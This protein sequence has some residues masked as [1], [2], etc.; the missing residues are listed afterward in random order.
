MDFRRI[1]KNTVQC[2][3]SEE[4]MNAYGFKVEDFFSDQQK[5]R[6]FLE[7]IVERA[8]EE[9]GYQAKSGM[10]SMQIMKMPN[11]DLAIT[12]SDRDKEEGFQSV[13][14]QFQQL[15]N[16]LDGSKNL[17]RERG[18]DEDAEDDDDAWVRELAAST[19]LD[20][21][22]RERAEQLEAESKRLKREKKFILAPKAYHFSSYTALEQFIA[23]IEVDRP[24]N[25][26]VYWE[27]AD[28]SYYMLVK[29]GRLKM[30]D[31]HL[32]CQRLSEFSVLFSAKPYVEEY[33]REHFKC[34]IPKQ[35]IR[36]LKKIE[37][38]E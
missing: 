27:E 38:G 35:A 30:D 22:L 20:D 17:P 28:D 7:H 34:V 21:E 8:E 6:E 12:F 11:N 5:S 9:V 33:C 2:I 18:V 4:E 26:S 16:M 32:L 23:A 19:E 24:I 25:S 36:V 1:D 15:A 13:L 29:K 37:T 14:Q 3:L 31:Y 10:V